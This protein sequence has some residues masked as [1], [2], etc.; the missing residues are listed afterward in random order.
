MTAVAP[1]NTQYPTPTL[2]AVTVSRRLAAFLAQQLTPAARVVVAVSGGADSLAL[3]HALTAVW[4]REQIV[5]AHLNH[6]MRPDAA[7]DAAFVAATA[8]AWGVLCRLGTAD[9]PDLAR[10]SGQSPEAAGRTARYRFL[11]E[12]ARAEQASAVLTAH[13]ADD[14]AETVL[15]HLLRGSGLNGLR[16]MLPVGLLPDAPDVRLLRPF[17]E[18]TRADL[19]A[20]CRE[21]DLQPRDDAS[22][23]DVR[24]LRNRVRQTALPAL[25]Q[26][27][28]RV[29]EHLTALATI[30][31]AETAL[32]DAATDQAWE[33]VTRSATAERIG[34]DLA[35]WRQLPTGLQRR[36]LWRA[37]QQLGAPGAG[38][39]FRPLEAA[40]L[41]ALTGLTGSRADLP[42]GW[43]VQ[44]GYAELWAA[45]SEARPLPAPQ[46]TTAT[47]VALPVPSR[48]ALQDGWALTA[49]W[50]T[51]DPA[52]AAANADPWRA[53]LALPAAAT[54]H[55][56]PRAPGERM[57][58]LGMHGHSTPL[59]KRLTARRIPAELR[60][61]W[62]IVAT[63][64]HIVWLVGCDV[65]HRVRVQPGVERVVCLWCGKEEGLGD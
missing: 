24:F 12:T 50:C 22:N 53:Y 48:I 52:E 47:A 27:N 41:I 10:R 19:H 63:A 25:E 45:Q 46:L 64:E 31:A 36:L 42:G 56:R 28:P 62:P 44:V 11:A 58:P 29:R 33:R 20:Y 21:H 59:K 65:D 38:T 39:A 3:L 26:L 43:F 13:H 9:V 6:Q 30:A 7:D 57:Q 54:L 2:P 5:A 23:R 40:R 16:G 60:A 1:P 17:L 34:W 32:L 61:R 35:A 15:L 14:Q 49:E 4:P 18:L 55:V 51:V 8:A 37:G